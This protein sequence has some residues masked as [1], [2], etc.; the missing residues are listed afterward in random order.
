MKLETVIAVRANK[1]I[2]RD[3]DKVIKVFDVIAQRDPRPCLTINAQV[4]FNAD[5]DNGCSRVTAGVSCSTKIER[6]LGETLRLHDLF[7]CGSG[8]QS[9]LR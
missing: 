4:G 1:T 3:G 8:E 2:Y 6:V 5:R 7:S 9:D